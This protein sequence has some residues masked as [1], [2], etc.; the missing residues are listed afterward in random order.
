[1]G[2]RKHYILRHLGASKYVLTKTRLLKQDF[3]VHGKIQPE[4][5]LTEVFKTPMAS[6]TSAPL[7]HGCPR[8]NACFFS[9]FRGPDRS[10]CPPNVCSGRAAWTSVGYPA[11]KLTLWAAISFLMF[12]PRRLQALRNFRASR[13]E[14][15][16]SCESCLL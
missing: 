12:V 11:P 1:M 14:I 6:W 7:G 8:R 3:P 10:F 9:G 2:P 13:T 4:F 5:F 16:N 15:L